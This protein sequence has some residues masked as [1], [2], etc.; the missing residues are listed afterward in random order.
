MHRFQQ[1]LLI[2]SVLALAWL[3]MQAVHELGHCV[4]AWATGGTVE[5]VVLHP[6]AISRTD[7]NPNPWPLI[8][9]WMGPVF[10]VLLPVFIW[11]VFVAFCSPFAWLPRFFAGYCLIAN[12]I[13]IGVGSFEGIGD[14]GDIVRHGSPV[15]VLWLF[16][17]VTVPT[18]LSLWNGLGPHFGFGISAPPIDRRVAYGSL[19]VLLATIV[20]ECLL[21]PAS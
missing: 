7:V 19:G 9:A 6:L 18:G 13:Y 11:G 2:A 1:L 20:V 21:S 12:G 14:A 17:L 4:G 15:W 8:V 5:Q 10:G 16:G 3:W